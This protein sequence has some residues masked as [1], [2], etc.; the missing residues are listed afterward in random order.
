MK[1]SEATKGTKLKAVVIGAQ[2]GVTFRTALGYMTEQADP[3]WD[4]LCMDLQ[5]LMV[6]RVNDAL[7]A[8]LAQIDSGRDG[9][10]ENQG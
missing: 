8:T 3:S 5:H 10:Q 9:G 4:K 7:V 1:E 2:M 6:G